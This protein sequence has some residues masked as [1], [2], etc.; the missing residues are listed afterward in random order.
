MKST[1]RSTA[2][3]ASILLA[4]L[5]TA[6]IATPAAAQT[7]AV[8]VTTHNETAGD[9]YDHRARHDVTPPRIADVT[10]AQGERVSERGWTRISARV[11]DRDTGV[12]SVL[13]RVDG[14]DVSPRVRIEEDLV[15]YAE[16]LPAGRHHAE[17]VV[18]DRAGNTARR[19]WSFEVAERDHRHGEGHYR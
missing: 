1:L 12:Q 14:R 17:L 6:M 18:R 15:R 2:A 9:H 3:A 10:P 16:D 5:G 13:L 7:R 11:G 4:S 19:T 8:V